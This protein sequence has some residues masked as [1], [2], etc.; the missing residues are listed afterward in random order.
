PANFAAFPAQKYEAERILGAGGFGVAF[1]CRNRHTGGR[2]V[3]KTLRRDGL[4][5][6]LNEVFREAQALEELDHPAII[7]VRDCD[8]ADP[9]R[10][11]PYLVMD[12]FEGQTLEELVQ[13]RGPLTPQELLSLARLVAEGLHKAHS[14]G[15]L[16]RDVKPGNLLVRRIPLPSPPASGGPPE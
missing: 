8:Y 12:Y 9:A 4:D 10:T 1:L 15:I 16:H 5:R 13:K 3:I 14:R 6:D 11:R 2:V 7:R